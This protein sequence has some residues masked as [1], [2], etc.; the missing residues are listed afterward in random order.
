MN[1]QKNWWKRSVDA[2][3]DSVGYAFIRTS[4]LTGPLPSVYVLLGTATGWKSLLIVVGVELIGYAVGDTAVK[5]AKKKIVPTK[6]ILWAIIAYLAT[7]EGL[8]LGYK[9][10]PTWT[11][12]G[13]G[14]VTLADAIQA[15][16]SVLFPL[17]T[18]AG[19]GLYAL[20]DHMGQIEGKE[21][22]AEQ[23]K[24]EEIKLATL[25]QIE[26]KKAALEEKRAQRKA[27]WEDERERKAKLFEVELEAKKA[28]LQPVQPVFTGNLPVT[29]SEKTGALDP[30]LREV[31]LEI[32][33]FYQADPSVS[34][35]KLVVA[36]GKNKPT[37][38]KAL[39]NLTDA[40]VVEIFKEGRGQ[41]VTVNG[42]YEDFIA[43][44]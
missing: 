33:P 26:D 14:T 8:M 10:I 41:R 11:L 43:N 4:P 36:T 16:V 1:E 30:D 7:I 25:L 27:E 28:A 20:Y 44:G 40:G 29:T 34:L 22:Q 35:N 6:W 17:F 32:L 23:L 37:L 13:M 19:A 42:K 24:T 18:L 9:V 38:H 12:V 31:Q 5:V 2:V 21:K 3:V 39:K 15:S